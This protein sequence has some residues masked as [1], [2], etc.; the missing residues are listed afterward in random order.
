MTGNP[1]IEGYMNAGI[2]DE[3]DDDYY[4]IALNANTK[5]FFHLKNLP[6]DYDM[7]LVNPSLTQAWAITQPGTTE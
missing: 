6:N 4:S 5:Y 2:H 1:F 3:F 7:Y